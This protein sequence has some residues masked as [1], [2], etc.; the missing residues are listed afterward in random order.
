MIKDKAPIS[1]NIFG[2]NLKKTGQALKT[3]YIKQAIQETKEIKKKADNIFHDKVAE[4][5]GLRENIVCLSPKTVSSRC[6]I[7]KFIT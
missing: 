1:K 4:L 5:K 7:F 2:V 6:I 3:D